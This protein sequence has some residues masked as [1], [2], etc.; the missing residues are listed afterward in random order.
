LISNIC[1]KNKVSK[2]SREQQHQKMLSAK[3]LY[4]KGFDL[5]II[6]DLI[7]VSRLTLSKWAKE[8]D[9]EGAKKANIIAL[10]AI[11]SIILQ[12]F[13]D[14]CEGK[15]PKISPDKA[16]KYAAAFEKLSDKRK[17]LTFMYEAFE[18]LTSDYIKDLEKAV[19][20]EDKDTSLENIKVLRD[21]MDKVVTR[22]TNEVLNDE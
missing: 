6:A 18:L 16:A 19:S 2:F 9:F 1:K 8:N 4:T 20:K 10:S 5:S 22:L 11:R 17:T 15:T 14:V 21:H 7:S 3:D 12:S 13:A